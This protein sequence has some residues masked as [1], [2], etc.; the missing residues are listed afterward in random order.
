MDFFYFA[1][2]ASRPIRILKGFFFSEVAPFPSQKKSGKR[3]GF[4]LFFNA[5]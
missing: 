2:G 4:P 3:E 1:I 5:L